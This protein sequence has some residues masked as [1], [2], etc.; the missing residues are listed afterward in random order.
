MYAVCHVSNCHYNFAAKGRPRKSTAAAQGKGH[1]QGG[2]SRR[3]G[4]AGGGARRDPRL[5]PLHE[6]TTAAVPQKAGSSGIR[7]ITRGRSASEYIPRSKAKDHLPEIP[8]MSMKSSEEVQ[9]LSVS[10]K[11]SPVTIPTSPASVPTTYTADTE[12]QFPS[13]AKKYLTVTDEPAPTGN[14]TDEVLEAS[15]DF[16]RNVRGTSTPIDISPEMSNNR[17]QTFNGEVD[18]VHTLDRKSPVDGTPEAV[19]LAGSL[20]TQQIELSLVD[21]LDEVVEPR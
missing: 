14:G 19:D 16:A 18:L 1:R 15:T 20:D 2:A 21:D 8:A 12:H 9:A 3:G 17:S 4:G 13:R 11:V 10:A 7:P 6:S 5:S